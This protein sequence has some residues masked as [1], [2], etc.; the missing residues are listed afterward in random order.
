MSQRYLGPYILEVNNNCVFEA[1]NNLICKR[2]TTCHARQESIYSYLLLGDR[3]LFLPQR[4]SLINSP[5]SLI[6]KFY[7][8]LLDK[9]KNIKLNKKERSKSRSVTIFPKKIQLT[10]LL[11]GSQEFSL[12]PYPSH[13]NRNS[14]C[15]FFGLY[16]SASIRSTSYSGLAVSLFLD[17][18]NF[19][20]NWKKKKQP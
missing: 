4:N 7:L 15:N 5:H 19:S 13:F 14:F 16:R 8:S 17:G 6:A 18:T 20:L 12:F 10:R 3:S 9:S 11:S 1:N 2:T